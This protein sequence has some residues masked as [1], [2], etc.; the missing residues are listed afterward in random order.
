[1]SHP[2]VETWRRFSVSTAPFILQEDSQSLS[3]KMRV[4]DSPKSYIESDIFCDKGDK[5]LHTGLYPI[6]YSGDLDKAKVFLLQL[7]PG[8]SPADYFAEY[9]DAE[10]RE[11]QTR[12]LKQENTDNDF[13]FI[14][15]DPRFCWHPGF[16]YWQGKLHQIIVKIKEKK[17]CPYR[18]ASSILSKNLA[19]LELLP[20][21][22]KNFGLGNG[23]LG[24]LASVRLIRSY[25]KDVLLPKAYDGEITIIVMRKANMWGISN[26]SNSSEHVIIYDA[27]ECRSAHLT[28]GSKGGDAIAKRLGLM[29]VG[30]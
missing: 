26:S 24:S 30:S 9:R 14:Y 4:F 19:M 29:N 15:I 8:F 2:L 17:N 16:G 23:L 11:A 28:I 3:G 7:N 18:E 27:S 20:Y 12:S 21:H 10:F 25:V 5:T 1:M 13:P 22:S 6:P